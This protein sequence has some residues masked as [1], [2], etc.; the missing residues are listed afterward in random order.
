M[1]IFYKSHVLTQFSSGAI[2]SN[3]TQME[4]SRMS[5]TVLL[6]HNFQSYKLC[7]CFGKKKKQFILTL[8]S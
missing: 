7:I 8:A 4:F 6:F 3:S 1:S 5:K 2:A